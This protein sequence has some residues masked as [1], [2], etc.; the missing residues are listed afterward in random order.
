MDFKELFTKTIIAQV[1][2]LDLYGSWSKLSDEELLTNKY[3]KT[4]EQLK[5]I[6]LVGDINELTKKDI[7]MMY[8]ALALAF[9]KATG[10]MASV[11]MEM[12]GEG[13]G[14]A[15]VLGQGL[16]LVDKHHR[17]AHRFGYRDLEKF[18]DDGAK[19]LQGAVEKFQTYKGGK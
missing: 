19:M 3:V 13:F 6:P 16:V 1:R 7:R 17:D 14:R 9:E 18:L 11:V 8:E 12:S 15:V 4:K 10:E 5:E 2:A